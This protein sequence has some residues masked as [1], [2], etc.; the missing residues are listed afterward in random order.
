MV[1]LVALLCW[2]PDA[3][4]MGFSSTNYTIDAAALG[5]V[6]G[7]SGSSNYQLQSSGG[8]AAIGNGS[9]G[10]YKLGA[11]YVA[12][13]ITPEITISV[14]PEGLVSYFTLD[15]NSGTVVHDA[16]LNANL[17]SFVGTPS[18]GTGQL[19]QALT[20]N[21]ANQAVNFSDTNQAQL[22]TG[23]IEAW[24]KTSSASGTV[25]VLGKYGSWELQL[26]S[27][28]PS[29]YNFSNSSTC[30]VPS[31][32][33]N[34]A[35]H[36]VALTLQSG[37]ANGSMISVDG[38]PITACTWTPSVQTG[39]VSLG[40]RLNAGVNSMYF[41]GSVDQVK[42]FS[43][44]LSASEIKA[45]YTAQSGGITSGLTLGTVLPGTSGVTS[46][47]I[48]A[49]TSG[50]SYNLAFSQDH[51]LTQGA[52]T[53][54]AMSGTVA[55]PVAWTEGTTKGLGFTLVSAS[56]TA[57]D[58]RWSGG[59]KFAALPGSATSIYTRS[60]LQTS[61][62]DT[63]KAQLRLDVDTSQP[64]GDYQNTLIVTGTPAL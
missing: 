42:V 47:D 29:F 53:I 21:G 56:A 1:A 61:S 14:Q 57:I 33:A 44:A 26:V 51:N 20:F 55:V 64:S 34:G 28:R 2:M 37:V 10:S 9:S 54:P 24:V 38:T 25:A 3:L 7:A 48:V 13:V 41:N 59:T 4:A 22:T 30:S 17:G 12:Q 32:I 35:W 46:F 45:E 18:W 39:I 15:E 63:I 31:S 62:K 60:G 5:N 19:D 6:G 49:L 58:S 52:Y 8:E 40:S 36:H 11:G 50:S 16:S 23:T 43:R 27:G